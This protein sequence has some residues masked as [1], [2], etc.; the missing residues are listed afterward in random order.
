MKHTGL[1]GDPEE[2]GKGT[3]NLVWGYAF[4]FGGLLQVIAGIVEVK[5]NN[6]FG[7]TAF[8]TYGGFW[9][10]LAMAHVLLD[11]DEAFNSKAIQ[12]MLVLMGIFTFI[13]WICT[14]K[15]NATIS[16]LFFLL[17]S[18]FCLL[19]GGVVNETVDK[20]A[21]WFGVATAATA[22]WLG[23]AEIINDIIGEG[24]D[25]IP[26][27]RFKQ[28]FSGGIHVAGRLQGEGQR[29][30]GNRVWMIISLSQTWLPQTLI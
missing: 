18:T 8:T 9:L 26:L 12:A 17:A 14:L 6:I 22:Y 16:L 28:S 15:M 7:F 13:M 20:T 3:E 10:S 30:V 5:R 1:G 25:I 27:G 11:D 19:A 24:H 23:A 4:F 21:G 29:Q 2:D